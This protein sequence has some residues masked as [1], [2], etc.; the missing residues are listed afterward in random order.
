MHAFKTGKIDPGLLAGL[1]DEVDIKDER[2]VIRPAVGED[3]CAIRMDDKYLVAKTDPITF[4]TERIGWYVVHINANDLATAGATPKW[5]LVTALL[6]EGR[7]DE[8]MMRSIWDDLNN[9][10]QEIGC[11]LC[12]G[13]TEVTAGLDRPILIGQMLGEV[14]MEKLVNKKTARPGDRVLLTKGVPVEG[15][16]ILAHEK[17]DMLK[18]ACSADKLAAGRRFLDEPGISVLKE[19]QIACQ[20]GEVHGMHDPTEGG[21]ATGLWEL[22]TACELGMWVNENNIRILQPG[23]D[24][25][26]ALGL[27]P[28]GV[29]ASGALLICV[30]PESANDVREAIESEGVACADVGEMR[31]QADGIKLLGKNGTRRDMP[32]FKQDEIGKLC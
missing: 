19:A 9:A 16:A 15:T 20:T 26:N 22:A 3:V 17:G 10:L 25:C 32:V 31:E 5:F 11:S 1:L 2:V 21:I 30:G 18:N 14:A 4:A 28:L 23:R 13:H 27:D 6:P 12:G 24:F 29:I 8:T 7:T